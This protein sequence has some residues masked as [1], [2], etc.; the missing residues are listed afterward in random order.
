ML[1]TL[2]PNLLVENPNKPNIHKDQLG[3]LPL[4]GIHNHSE[5]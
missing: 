2:S 4:S 1:F 5:T 3:C